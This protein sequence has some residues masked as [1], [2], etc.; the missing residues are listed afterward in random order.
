MKPRRIFLFDFMQSIVDDLTVNGAQGE[1]YG[2]AIQMWV[3]TVSAPS[4]L[5]QFAIH[6]LIPMNLGNFSGSGE[7]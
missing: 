3:D 5:D 6:P 1:T 4:P 7:R 2:E